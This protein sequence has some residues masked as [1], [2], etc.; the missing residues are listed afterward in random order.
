M[1]EEIRNIWQRMRAKH[2]VTVIN[3]DT[4]AERMHMRLSLINL[5]L[6]VV[7]LLLVSFIVFALVIWFSPLKNYLPGYNENIRQDLVEETYRLDSLQHELDL[8]TAYLN[9]IREV[10]SGNVHTD[11]VQSL[12][13][14]AIQEKE[15]LLAERSQV[16]DE[17]VSNYEAREHDNLLLFD[18]TAMHPVTTLFRPVQGVITESFDLTAKRYGITLMTNEGTS[19][20]ATLTGTIVFENYVP[21]EGWM[22]MVQHDADYLSL[23]YGLLKPFKA[24]G[25]SVQAGETLGLVAGETVRFELWQRGNPLNPEEVIAF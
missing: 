8:Q 5:L 2:R 16:V 17:F 22:L 15:A 12:D 3:E 20:S 24:V 4:L 9:S 21:S 18:V 13:S 11:S 1:A 19:V 10:V 7:A 23:Y 25:A 14:M 6:V